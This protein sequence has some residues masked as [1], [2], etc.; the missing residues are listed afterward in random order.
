MKIALGQVNLTIGNIQSN[1]ENIISLIEKAIEQNAKLIIF[2]EQCNT[3]K[4]AKDLLLIPQYLTQ[5]NKIIEQLVPYSDKITILLGAAIKNNSKLINAALLIQNGKIEKISSASQISEDEQTWFEAEKYNKTFKLDEYTFSVQVG[6]SPNNE[7]Q[8]DFIIVLNSTP[9]IKDKEVKPLKNNQTIYINHTGL[10]NNLVYNGG[11]F[12]SDK[13]GFYLI[14]APL[15][16]ETLSIFDTKDCQLINEISPCKEE[17]IFTTLSFAFKEFCR[18]NKFNKAVIGLSGGIDSA[19]SATIMC[20]AIGADNVLGI[21]MPSK[22][23]TESSWND[24]YDLAKNLGME[25][26]TISIK[27]LFDTFINDIQNQ[28]YYDTAEENLQARLRGNILMSFSNRE[29]RILVSTGNKSE[30]SMG[31]CTL[32]GDTCGGINLICDLY[33]QEVYAV[34]KWINRNNEIIPINTIQKAP[35]AELRPDQKDQDFLPEYEVLDE[36]LYRYLEMNEEIETIA[37]KFDKKLVC[38]IIN[39][40]N[41]MEFKRNQMTFSIK[42]SKKALSDRNYPPINSFKYY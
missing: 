34:S 37:K 32:Y 11:S 27:P 8:T 22:Y 33:K 21:T 18:I 31:Y 5:A 30:A 41:T 17:K 4:G 35:S 19:L 40:L 16:E 15:L 26:K 23:S 1:F 10:G 20:N 9:Y 28:P 14:K 12:V 38:E 6:E 25:C 2:P 3:V 7:N 36:I 24:S 29:N 39:K 42:I 13:N